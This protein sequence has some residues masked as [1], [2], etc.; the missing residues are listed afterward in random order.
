M[1]P[2]ISFKD[3]S[4]FICAL[5]LIALWL[6]HPKPYIASD[7]GSYSLL[8]FKI[9]DGSFFTHPPAGHFAQR[10]GVTLP[11]AACYTLFG[12]NPI[13][14]HLYLLLVAVGTLYL[15]WRLSDGPAKY[16]ACLLFALSLPQ[17]SC[18]V[19]LLPDAV[20][21]GY[22]LLA[23]ASLLHRGPDSKSP[24]YLPLLAI[25]SLLM[26][27]SAK[28]SAYW[29]L[30][31]W[32]IL[33]A[34]DLYHK[35]YKLMTRFYLPCFL[36]GMF[37]ALVF[38]LVSY[39]I[40]HNPLIRFGQLHRWSDLV[41]NQS[42]AWSHKSGE[43]FYRLSLGPVVQ[44]ARDYGP[45]FALSVGGSIL[46]FPKMR[47]WILCLVSCLTLYWFGS[48]S[49]SH[50]EP[51]ILHSRYILPALPFMCIIAG[52]FLSEILAGSGLTIKVS[53][54]S[55]LAL[56]LP[57]LILGIG[58]MGKSFDSI[59]FLLSVDIFFL[60]VIY[61]L[62]FSKTPRSV[63][64]HM[65][66]IL[67]LSM[68]LLNYFRYMAHRDLNAEKKC[69]DILRGIVD[70]NDRKLLLLCS[71]IRSPNAVRYYFGYRVPEN[72]TV[73]FFGEQT[74][75]DEKDR[76]VYYYIHSD[77]SRYLKKSKSIANYDAM[78]LERLTEKVVYNREGIYLIEGKQEIQQINN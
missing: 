46:L 75:L 20:V 26:A 64:A 66:I 70:R 49:L 29:I 3:H 57:L 2:R 30:P 18:S 58:L 34:R 38:L 6:I 67:M 56:L 19:A 40:W 50:Y 11:V 42:W 45:V 1:V 9:S 43:L 25:I 69:V 41:Q 76:R 28:E 63:V 37:F 68:P 31:V 72:L 32:M 35:R 7:P 62:S 8:A 17:Y 65:A 73:K 27:F 53:W 4:F 24:L 55:S 22:M 21:S 23:A 54:Q 78:I 10:L 15:I 48:S 14:T 60:V 39:W 51:L 44:L 5:L 52:R 13:T 61:C 47:F 59:S 33:F 36:W 12:V 77:R 74:P 71:D 16:P